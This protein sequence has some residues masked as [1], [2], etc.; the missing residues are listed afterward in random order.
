VLVLYT[1]GVKQ[2]YQTTSEVLKP[3]VLCFVSNARFMLVL[4][5][6][7]VNKYI[8]ICDLIYGPCFQCRLFLTITKATKI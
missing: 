3:A 2:Q 6:K 4:L 7:Y 5:L 8:L 1:D